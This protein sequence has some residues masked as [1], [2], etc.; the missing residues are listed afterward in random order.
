MLQKVTLDYDFTPLLC[1]DYSKYDSC[2][3]P[4]YWPSKT[5]EGRVYDSVLKDLIIEPESPHLNMD[6]TMVSMIEWDRSQ[7]DFDA[8]G[9]Q[10]DMQVVTVWSIKQQPQNIVPLH[11]DQFRTVRDMVPNHPGTICRVVIHL[12]H[13][14]SGQF[15]EYNGDVDTQWTQ[16]D[17]CMFGEDVLHLSA[18][19]GDYPKYTMQVSGYATT[20]SI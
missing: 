19:C 8:I 1:A 11:T 5:D 4:D 6:N 13:W 17:G 2:Y 3:D 15:I 16:G 18:N 20:N 10:L 9:K 14:H 7:L 12:E